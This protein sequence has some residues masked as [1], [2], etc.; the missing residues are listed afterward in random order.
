MLKD[1][2][3]S[4]IQRQEKY[5]AQLPTG[6]T[7]PLFNSK[8]ALQSQRRNG[9]RDT[10]SAARELVDNALEA[11]AK[12]IHVVFEHKTS[13]Q[14]RDLVTAIAFIDDGSGI[15]FPRVLHFF[16]KDLDVGRA[17]VSESILRST[18]V[19]NGS[20]CGQL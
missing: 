20:K 15:P 5:L 16:Y 4:E 17:N 8:V 19:S 13:K 6:F 1:R 12:R 7:F 10:A 2:L 14:G 3:L 11:G 18:R 9:Y